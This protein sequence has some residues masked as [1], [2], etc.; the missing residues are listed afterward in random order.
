MFHRLKYIPLW[1]VVVAGDGLVERSSISWLHKL[2]LQIHI[3]TSQVIVPLFKVSFLH[4][5]KPSG[6]SFVQS[7][8]QICSSPVTKIFNNRV[9]IF[10]FNDLTTY[11]GMNH[12]ENWSITC[13]PVWPTVQ[14]RP[15]CGASPS[16]CWHL[17]TPPGCSALHSSN[18]WWSSPWQ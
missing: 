4:P 8:L 15:K 2:S 1:V 12:T 18:I 13:I 14:Y 9:L 3:S 7:L 10:H 17:T 6:G 16:S 5:T 11:Q